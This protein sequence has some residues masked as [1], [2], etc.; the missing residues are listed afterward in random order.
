MPDHVAD[1]GV[2]EGIRAGEHDARDD[3]AAEQVAP[4]GGRTTHL[5]IV[6]A[7]LQLDANRLAGRRLRPVKAGTNKIAGNFVAGTPADDDTPTAKAVY[8]QAA[9][10]VAV[11]G[12]VQ[13]GKWLLRPIQTHGQVGIDGT[14]HRARVDLGPR[15]GEGIEQHAA[16]RIG[17]R[18]QRR[19]GRDDAGHAECNRI[20]ARAGIGRLQGR[21]QRARAAGGG[22]GA[23]TAVEIGRVTQVGHV[24][25][26]DVGG[27]GHAELAGVAEG[28]GGCGHD[29]VTGLRHDERRKTARHRQASIGRAVRDL[30]NE[31]VTCGHRPYHRARFGL[32]DVDGHGIID[33]GRVAVDT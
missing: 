22:T 32:V 24:E 19:R 12:N 13:A 26:R 33:A 6:R 11:T 1:Q 9:H 20:A 17:Q 5:V 28:I 2:R 15:R 10:L 27:C 21:A 25:G 3:V 30:A 8:G 14:G 31:D 23:V 16:A 29:Q 4:L 18:R 7:L